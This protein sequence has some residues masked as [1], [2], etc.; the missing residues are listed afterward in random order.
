M[1]SQ[2]ST[3]DSQLVTVSD[4]DA[5]FKEIEVLYR[6][7]KRETIKLTAPSYRQAQQ[8]ALKLSQT[9]NPLLITEA[10]LPAEYQKDVERFLGRLTPEFG[11]FVEAV[12]FA[13]TFGSEFQKK[14][15]QVGEKLM[16]AMAST[17]S[18]PNSPSSPPGSNPVKSDDSPSP[19]CESTSDSPASAKSSAI[20]GG[21]SSPVAAE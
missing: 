19:N 12:S 9:K 20:S 18:V 16:Q 8:V 3:P 7:G 4:H 11:A 13:L 15:Q 1:D 2:L 6:N 21:S 5:G 14:M 10:C 17:D